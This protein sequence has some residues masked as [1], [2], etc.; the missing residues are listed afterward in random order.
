MLGQCRRLWP[1]IG[2]TLLQIYILIG[3]VDSTQLQVFHQYNEFVLPWIPSYTHVD[4]YVI[5]RGHRADLLRAQPYTAFCDV[6]ICF[7][8]NKTD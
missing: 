4:L 1:D 2:S 8:T 5:P 7:V 3:S 6:L